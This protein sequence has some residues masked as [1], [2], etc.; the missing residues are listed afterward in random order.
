M[1]FFK[2]KTAYELRISD[3][4][5]DVCSS[6]LVFELDQPGPD[7]VRAELGRADLEVQVGLAA[8][9]RDLA[10]G[11]ADLVALASVDPIVGRVLGHF[12]DGDDGECGGDVEGLEGAREEAVVAIGEGPEGAGH[13]VVP[14]RSRRRTP[15]RRLGAQRPHAA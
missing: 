6:D 14:F 15:T 12:V 1:F 10:P 9:L 2:Q 8:R 7:P 4:S 13:S 11:G 5:S 3:W